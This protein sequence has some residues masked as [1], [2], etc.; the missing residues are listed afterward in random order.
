MLP[1]YQVIIVTV[2]GILGSVLYLYKPDVPTD[3][4]EKRVECRN[5]RQFGMIMVII[6]SIGALYIIFFSPIS[7]RANMDSD[8]N[9]MTQQATTVPQYQ[10]MYGRKW[11]D[12]AAELGGKW[13]D[14]GG[15]WVDIVGRNTQ[16]VLQNPDLIGQ[17]GQVVK[18][19]V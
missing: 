18:T 5:C 16:T 8:M 17:F 7:V 11:S 13:V 3:S 1:L 12:T 2:L 9:S 14:L 4:E 19:F 6:A 15:K 10:P